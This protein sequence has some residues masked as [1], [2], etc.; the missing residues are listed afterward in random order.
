MCR[1][2]SYSE[3]ESSAQGLNTIA[4]SLN[5]TEPGFKESLLMSDIRLYVHTY[6]K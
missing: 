5:K 2:I 6:N 1:E 3:V 4:I